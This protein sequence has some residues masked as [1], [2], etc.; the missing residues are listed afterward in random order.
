MCSADSEHPPLETGSGSSAGD[1]S[2]LGNPWSCAE[3]A[4]SWLLPSFLP[5][6]RLRGEQRSVITTLRRSS[7]GHGSSLWLKEFS[8]SSPDPGDA[9]QGDVDGTVSKPGAAALV[10]S[11]PGSFLRRGLSTGFVLLLTESF[12]P[13]EQQ[14]GACGVFADVTW[15]GAGRK[16]SAAMK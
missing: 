15:G 14:P 4:A 2:E 8:P 13:L 9:A 11:Q 10:A 6:L 7:Q 5:R 12:L 1:G 3:E 16:H